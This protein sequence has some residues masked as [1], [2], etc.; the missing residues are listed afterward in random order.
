MKRLLI[1]I[2][3]LLAVSLGLFSITIA[4]ATATDDCAPK[5]A[6]TETTGWVAESPGPGWYQVDKRTT[7]VLVEE[8][9]QR[10]SWNGPWESNTQPPPFPD[11]RWQP[12]VKGDPH[13][14]GVEGPYFRSHGGSGKGDWFYLERVK[15]YDYLTEYRFAFDH[16]AVECPPD[17][18]EQPEPLVQETSETSLDCDDKVQVTIHTV[19]TTPYVWDEGTSEWVLGEPWNAVTVTETP[20]E[21]G[22]CDEPPVECPTIGRPI[23]NPDCQPPVSP[24]VIHEVPE[25]PSQ[26]DQPETP[27]MPEVPTAVDAGLS[28]TPTSN[29]N[30]LWAW[31]VVGG[32]ALIGGAGMR[33]RLSGN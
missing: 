13:N 30:S 10:Y 23:Y 1:T 18:P 9:W 15:V 16:P 27:A 6:W 24:P 2:L 17:Q 3:T 31:L 11:P 12:N 14:V 21:P 28:S 26:P 7:E 20:V 33:R 5:D 29:D 4:P 32:L 19:T 8:G 22:Q 25:Q